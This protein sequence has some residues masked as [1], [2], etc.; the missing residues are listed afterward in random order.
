[1]NEPEAAGQERPLARRESVLGFLGVV[2][3][4]QSPH[5]QVPLDRIDRAA[6]ARV[7][8]G[9]KA[10]GRQQQKARIKLFAAVDLYEAPELMVEAAPTDIAMN[11]RRYRSPAIDGA[12]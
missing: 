2:A 12:G 1:M 5:E 4:H 10:Y 7:I 11:F 9:Q 6:Y 8:G 3:H